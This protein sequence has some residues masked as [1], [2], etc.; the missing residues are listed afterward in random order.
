MSLVK[1]FGNINAAMPSA[2][3]QSEVLSLIATDIAV[4]IGALEAVTVQD[5][6]IMLTALPHHIKT[7]LSDVMLSKAMVSGTNTRVT[8]QD[9]SGRMMEYNT[10]LASILMW[11]YEDYFAFLAE[12]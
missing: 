6:T 12:A 10:L 5:V 7:R 3:E 4:R 11:V 9:Y 1:Q 2:L 8:V